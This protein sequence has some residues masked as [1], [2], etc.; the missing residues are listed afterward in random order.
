MG[1]IPVDMYMVKGA[2]VTCILPVILW[3]PNPGL[4]LALFIPIGPEIALRIKQTNR[5]HSKWFFR[6]GNS[7]IGMPDSSLNS[8][9]DF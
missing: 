7:E 6:N 4:D 8:S 5:T 3:I 1:T 2:K 9:Y